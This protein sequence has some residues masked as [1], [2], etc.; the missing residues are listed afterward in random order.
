[1]CADCALLAD[2]SAPPHELLVAIEGCD[3]P[4][5]MK[6]RCLVCN[7]HH[8]LHAPA[9]RRNAGSRASARRRLPIR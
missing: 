7:T 6:Y 4:G 3:T 9:P 8:V 2:D 5:T 1:M